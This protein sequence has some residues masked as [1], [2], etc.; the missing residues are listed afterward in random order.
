MKDYLLWL[1]EDWRWI[2]TV[3]AIFGLALSVTAMVVA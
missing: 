2:P 1:S 3:L